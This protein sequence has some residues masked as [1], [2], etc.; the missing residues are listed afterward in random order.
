M[1]QSRSC[2]VISPIGPPDS[3]VRNHADDVYRFIIQPRMFSKQGPLNINKPLVDS[4]DYI[5]V[6]GW[7]TLTLDFKLLSLFDQD[8][9]RILNPF[10]LPMEYP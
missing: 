9:H 7:R 1:P 3:R 2:F 10:L 8:V 6:K 4:K 5:P